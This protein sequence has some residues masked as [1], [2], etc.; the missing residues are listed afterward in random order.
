VQGV[1]RWFYNDDVY[2]YVDGEG[3]RCKRVVLQR[4][5]LGLRERRYCKVQGGGF[6]RTKFRFT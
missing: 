4:G 5:S 6:T 3:G 2:V 1:E